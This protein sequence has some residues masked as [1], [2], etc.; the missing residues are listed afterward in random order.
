MTLLST[1]PTTVF[2][3]PDDRTAP[4]PAELRGLA[5]DGVRLLVAGPSLVD[6]TFTHLGD[7]LRPG[8]VLVVN[9][10]ATVPGQVDADSSV[11][12]RVVV[13]IANRLNDGTRVVE[14]RTRPNAASPILDAV[15]GERLR[16]PEGAEVELLDPYPVASSSPTGAGNRLWRARVQVPGRLDDYLQR[17]ARPISYGYLSRTFSLAYYQTVFALHPGSA[18]MPSAGRPFTPDLVTR[19]VARGILFAPITLHT[20][21]SSQ[22]SHEAPQSEW[23]EVSASTARLVNGARA[24]GGRVVAVGTT[25]TRALESATDDSGTLHASCGWTDL[26]ISTER[27]VRLVDG[28]VTGWHN[29][30]AS[31]LLLVESV[32]GAE[33]T[34]AAYDAAVRQGY[35]W[36]EFGDSC[37]LLP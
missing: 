37:L 36:H 11:R 12:G 23:F 34:Q 15:A 29:P 33:L 24:N 9:T 27:P 20:G 22:E 26:V 25:A 8:D 28:L 31:H 4:E 3:A 10:S 30:D 14:L 19:L 16:L 17:R 7:H 18:E 2:T 13:H 21:V 6:T 5:R 32:V 35:L 1:T